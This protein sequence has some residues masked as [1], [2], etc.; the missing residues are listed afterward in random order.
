MKKQV[1]NLILLGFVWLIGVKAACAEPRKFLTVTELAPPILIK[2][3]Q[4]EQQYSGQIGVAML[5]T[6]SHII[7]GY[8]LNQRFPMMSTFKTLACANLLNKH[9]KKEISL[10]H[11]T[12][13][14]AKDIVS[15]SPVTKKLIGQSITLHQACEATMIMSDNTAANIILDAINGPHELTRFLRSIGDDITRLDR[16]EPSLNSAIK[17][18]LR[19]TSTP[20]AMVLSLQKILFTDVLSREST[21]QLTQWMLDTTIT[22][23]L[24]RSVLPKEWT[25]ADRSGAGAFGSRGI[26]AIVWPNDNQPIIISIYITQSLA[27]LS[28]LND[29]IAE[30][31]KAIFISMNINQ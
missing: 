23:K 31:G 13:V 12:I 27:S 30:I 8:K 7:T 16:N 15:W 25:I 3:Q 11:S 14:Q 21:G 9:D 1:T 19:D 26:T 4:L 5:D 2:V 24:L 29:A 6:N 22:S 10:H 28:E 20:Q 18:D 17:G